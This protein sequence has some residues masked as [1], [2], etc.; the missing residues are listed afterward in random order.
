M[1]NAGKHFGAGSQGKGDGSGA[2]T[3][4]DKDMIGE[5]D[6]LSNRDKEPRV[7]TR[8][9]DGK[10]TQTDQRQD[11]SANQIPDDQGEDQR[12]RIEKHK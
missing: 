2:G 3:I 7:D 12:A 11:H 4:L 6:V 10:G 8:G 1:A 5:N 9:Y